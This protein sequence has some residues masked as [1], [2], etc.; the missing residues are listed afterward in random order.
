MLL[1]AEQAEGGHRH[2]RG[3]DRGRH[4]HAHA[5]PQVGVRRAE[6]DPEHDA[7]D[8]GA[9]RELGGRLPARGLGHGARMIRELRS[10]MSAVIRAHE[11]A[12]RCV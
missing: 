5:Q 9:Q 1:G 4:G 3:R 10:G 11:H 7:R 8:D 12:A 6:H 2:H